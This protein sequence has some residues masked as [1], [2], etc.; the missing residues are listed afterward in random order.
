[1]KVFEYKNCGT[2][3][4]ALKFLE[5]KNIPFQKIPI[6][7]NPPSKEELKKAISQYK[8]NIKKIINTSGLDY[9]S[10]NLKDKLDSMKESEIIELLSSNGN[11]VK[12]PFVV[13]NSKFLVGFNESEWSKELL[14]DV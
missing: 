7:E 14:D 2:C 1:M 11:L 8:G 10:L 3:R 12:R 6:R 13:Y 4:K 9:K 5:S